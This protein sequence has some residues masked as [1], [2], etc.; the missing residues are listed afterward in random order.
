MALNIL[1]SYTRVFVEEHEVDQTSSF[2][3]ALLD[4][5]EKHLVIATVSSQQLSILI[6]GGSEEQRAPFAR[7]A[8]PSPL[9]HWICP[10]CCCS[11]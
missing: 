8:S 6:V 2:Y 3:Q 11:A 1:K 4:G 5:K 10:Y 7:L 9:T